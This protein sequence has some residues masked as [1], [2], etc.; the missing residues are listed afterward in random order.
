MKSSGSP[1]DILPPHLLKEVF[2]AIGRYILH[3][4]NTSLASCVAPP[5]FKHAVVQPLLKKPGLDTL[6]PSNCHPISKLPFLAKILERVVYDQ[7]STHLAAHNVMD[8]FQSGFRPLHSTE[9]SLLRVFNDIFMVTASGSCVVLVLLDLFAAFDT[10]DHNILLLRLEEVA[11]IQGTA[12]T[13]FMSYL[14]D[15]SQRVV[16][17]NISSRT[18]PLSCGVPQGSILGPLLFSLYRLPLSLILKQHSV[19]YHLYADDCQIYMSVKPQQSIRPLLDCVHDVKCWL[20]T[21]CLH[22]NDS[23]TEL[24]LFNPARP[25]AFQTPD[26]SSIS[27][28]LKTVVTNLGVKMDSSPRMDAQVNATVKSCFFQLRHLVKLKAVLSRRIWNQ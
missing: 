4:I 13:W 18:A 2:P 9:S 19:H 12:L 7:Q 27:P 5:G 23:K 26:F 25:S 6:A 24:I 11:A 1:D 22:L 20:T 3:F 8:V 21:N 16:L 10:V 17:N 14:S 28:N 15:R